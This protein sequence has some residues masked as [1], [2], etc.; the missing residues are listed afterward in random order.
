MAYQNV[1]V[2][3]VPEIEEK[4]IELEQTKRNTISTLS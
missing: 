1:E 3:L 2:K 4:K